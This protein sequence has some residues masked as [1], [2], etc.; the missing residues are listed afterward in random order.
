MRDWFRVHA[1]VGPDDRFHLG[2]GSQSAIASAT[3]RSSGRQPPRYWNATHSV[4]LPRAADCCIARVMRK[5]NRARL[6]SDAA[7][8]LL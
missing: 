3:K 2:A 7:L 6:T 1:V 5:P 4:V 8:L